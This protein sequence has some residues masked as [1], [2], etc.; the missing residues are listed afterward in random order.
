MFYII[1]QYNLY[2][3]ILIL[4]ITSHSSRRSEFYIIIL[5]IAIPFILNRFQFLGAFAKL[6]KPT[7]SFI[8]SVHPHE[9]T[10]LLLDGFS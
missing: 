5:E 10:R 2:C 4:K 1:K 9:P 3:S 7:I 6:Q 8:M